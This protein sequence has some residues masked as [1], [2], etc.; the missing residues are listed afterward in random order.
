MRYDLLHNYVQ[1][2]GLTRYS[3]PFP[4]NGGN[5]VSV[6]LLALAGVLSSVTVQQS[7]DLDNWT[8]VGTVSVPTTDPGA[9]MKAVLGIGGQYCRLKIV[10]G[11]S[12]A[13]CINAYINTCRV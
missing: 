5:A 11:A 6:Q 12:A 7:D 3:E 13:C 10:T 2:A 8:S 9:A 1:A 4:M